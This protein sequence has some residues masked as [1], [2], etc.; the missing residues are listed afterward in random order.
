MKICSVA[1]F[2]ASEPGLGEYGRHIAREFPR[3]IPDT[4][5]IT[6]Q[7]DSLPAEPPLG[8][9]IDRC[10]LNPHTPAE[11]LRDSNCIQ[12][13]QYVAEENIPE[14]FMT[15]LFVE[16]Q[17]MAMAEQNASAMASRSFQRVT[18]R[19]PSRSVVFRAAAPRWLPWM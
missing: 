16:R 6:D 1:E 14:L 3:P 7:R 9:T 15:E 13:T 5:A 17:H 12:F 2:Q 4:S 19:V 11:R 10:K 18:S 8:N